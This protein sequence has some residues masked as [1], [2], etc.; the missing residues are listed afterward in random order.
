MRRSILTF[1]VYLAFKRATGKDYRTDNFLAVLVELAYICHKFKK[2]M[3]MNHAG[4]LMM[5]SGIAA[6][7]ALLLAAS[8]HA[9]PLEKDIKVFAERRSAFMAQ[10]E[11]DAVAIFPSKPVYLRN[12]DSEYPY[13]QESNFY[14]LSGFEEPESILLI[15][16]SAANNKYVMFVRERN[17]RRETYDGPRAGIEGAMTEFKADTALY[18]DNVERVL[19]RFI[20]HDRPIYYT[21]GI[22]SKVDD[23]M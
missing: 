6:A 4:E 1:F 8:V 17:R 9:Q 13:R 15:D 5:K 3:Q 21:F 10:M 7:L 16:P 20:R 2:N 19:F 12:L 14:Y 23:F 11:P 18:I 22:N